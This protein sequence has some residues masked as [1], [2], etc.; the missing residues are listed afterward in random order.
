MRKQRNL[1]QFDFKTTSF[2]SI[3]II[4]NQHE[5]TYSCSNL[6]ERKSSTNIVHSSKSNSAADW[7]LPSNHFPYHP[8]TPLTFNFCRLRKLNFQKI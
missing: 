6:K 2:T 4:I 8:L 3:I 1:K 7:F 5:Y